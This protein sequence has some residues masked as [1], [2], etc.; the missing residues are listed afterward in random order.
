MQQ[1][2]IDMTK[3]EWCDYRKTDSRIDSGNYIL[4][5]CPDH[6]CAKGKGHIFEH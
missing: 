2:G 4:V 6:P 3:I 1:A 5:Y